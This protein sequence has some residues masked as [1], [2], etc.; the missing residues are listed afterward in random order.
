[1]LRVLSLFV[2]PSLAAAQLERSP[3]SYILSPS[4]RS[5]IR[6]SMFEPIRV[7]CRLWKHMRLQE[8]GIVVME[9]A[10]TAIELTGTVDEHQHLQLDT[11]LPILGPKRVRVIVLYSPTDELD[12]VEWLH[13]AA[14]NPAFNDLNAPDE[15]IYSLED[16]QP[17]HAQV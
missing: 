2:Q 6:H 16:G 14:N 11:T 7:H 10:L 1:M 13:A 17:F 8:Q 4:I 3:A 12:E 9:S 15:D 5:A